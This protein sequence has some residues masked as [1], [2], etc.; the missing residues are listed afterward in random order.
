MTDILG[1]H[2]VN[3]S[4]RDLAKSLAWYTELFGFS[5]CKEM[6][7]DGQRGAKVVMVHSDSKILLG[8]TSYS[9]N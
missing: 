4:V 2:H 5:V 3:L 7:G 1:F 8:L 6:P 9:A